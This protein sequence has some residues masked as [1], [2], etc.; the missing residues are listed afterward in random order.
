MRS[1]W[2]GEAEVMCAVQPVERVRQG[3][4]WKLLRVVSDPETVAG[5]TSHCSL[6]RKN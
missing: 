4:H 6:Q 1:L 3:S 2:I 5:G